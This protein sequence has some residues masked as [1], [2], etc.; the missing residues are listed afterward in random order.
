MANPYLQIENGAEAKRYELEI[1]TD[2]VI[3][4]RSTECQWVVS[5]GAVSTPARASEAAE[6]WRSRSRI[7]AARTARS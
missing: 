3:I 2:D 7:S 5:S 4:G 1:G 6:R